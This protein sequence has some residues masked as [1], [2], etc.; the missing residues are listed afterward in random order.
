MSTVQELL[1]IEAAEMRSSFQK[2][3]M[4][5]KTSIQIAEHREEIMCNFLKEYLPKSFQIGKGEI[6]DTK[7]GRS[8]EVDVIVCN[9]WH[10]FS[11]SGRG[12]GLFF[13]EGVFCAI[14]VKT[15]L[16]D[17]KELERAVNQVKS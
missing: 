10:P 16:G 8:T 2:A 15:N 12:R 13:A 11:V 5:Y 7:G 17:V 1:E 9:Q 4:K 6:I 14:E 3:S